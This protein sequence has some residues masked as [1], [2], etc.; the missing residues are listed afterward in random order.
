[1][2]RRSLVVL[3]VLVLMAGLAA[4]V[5]AVER[6]AS[7]E[8]DASW[9][10]ILAPGTNAP[11]T[12]PVLARRHSG[13]VGHVYENI[14]QGFEFRGS[15]AAADALRRNPNVVSVTSNGTVHTTE[16]LPNSV[17]RIDGWTAHQAGFDGRQ[18]D[19]TPVRIAILDTGI[20]LTHVDLAPNLVA[21]EGKNCIFDGPPN[22]DQGHGTHVAGSAAGAFNGDG[23][24]GIATDASLAAVKVLDSTGYG[25]DADVI[26]GLDHVYTLAAD[27]VPTVINLSLGEAKTET[28]DCASSPT[29]QAICNLHDAGV[30]VVA[31]AGNSAI[32]TSGFVPA[33]YPETIAVS[34][35]SDLDG[36]VADTGCDFFGD[37]L[38]SC[39]ETLANFTNF[40]ALVDVAAPG[41]QVLSA[42]INGGLEIKS[43]TSMASPH[44]AG[45]AA[46]MLGANP[47]LTPEQV[48][49]VLRETGECPDGT[50][51]GASTC[52]GKGIWLMS[53]VFGGA[54]PES[55]GIPEPLVNALRAAEAAAGQPV[56]LVDPAV[57]ITAP[58]DGA[59]ILGT[60]TVSADASD[61]VAV[62][63]VEFFVDGISIGADTTEPYT[64]TWDSASSVNGPAALEATASDSS[65]N[66]ATDSIGITIDN[67]PDLV[68]P[69]V[70]LTAPLDGATVV[71]SITVTADASD[72]VA[73]ASVEFF[74]DGLS[75]GIDTTEPYASTWD[76]ASGSNGSH[77]VSAVASD[78]TGNSS[79]D[80][81]SVTVDN[82]VLAEYTPI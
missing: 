38:G 73:V 76:T 15:Q 14:F 17:A 56:D 51:S 44:V 36:T 34:A 41:V 4:P 49:S 52:E 58:A 64:L 11:E 28:A 81:A 12:A 46:L 1:M 18:P 33:S 2:A 50:I 57:T 43:G 7:T 37:I 63:S 25:T 21:S 70:T 79:S 82:P 66:T 80:Q 35:F 5:G 78:P 59:T 47:G 39:D 65:G 29:H 13:S 40:G 62:A 72:D 24:V 68:D 19:G 67:P 71:G 27:G 75:I 3:S 74:V 20:N 23:A 32:D 53:G 10:V 8:T 26:C 55:D 9:I 42:S 22:D 45:V 31:A 54:S 77:T 69:T 60:I 16:W 61:D 6:P 30:V 48:R